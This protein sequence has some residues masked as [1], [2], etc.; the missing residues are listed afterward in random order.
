[1]KTAPLVLR[2]ALLLLSVSASRGNW[3]QYRGPGASGLDD[4]TPLPT[5]WNI[6]TGQNIRWQTPIPGLA[7]SAPIVWGDRV[8]VAT[9]V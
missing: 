9:A 3:P 4:T 1:M 5:T 2:L 8:Y 7:H 6:A